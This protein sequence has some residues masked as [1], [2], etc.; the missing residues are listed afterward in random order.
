[1]AAQ[2]ATDDP[3]PEQPLATSAPIARDADILQIAKKELHRAM[4]TW[5]AVPQ[6]TSQRE[7]IINSAID[8]A[9]FTL[10]IPAHRKC[11]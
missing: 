1:M 6:M 9:M 11:I 8:V 4:F 2:D 10:N 3:Q 7:E 5:L